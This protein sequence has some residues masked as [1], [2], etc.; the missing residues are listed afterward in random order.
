MDFISLSVP[1]PETIE[2]KKSRKA[3]VGNLPNGTVLQ[4]YILEQA[5]G[6]GGFGITPFSKK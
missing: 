5:I 3:I 1:P 2:P 6:Q 4:N